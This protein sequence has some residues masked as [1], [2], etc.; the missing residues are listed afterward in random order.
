MYVKYPFSKNYSILLLK[1]KEHKN[2]SNF[3]AH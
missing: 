2:K 3:N 1:K